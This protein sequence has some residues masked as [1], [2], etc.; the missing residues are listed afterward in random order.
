[1]DTGHRSASGGI[2]CC[3][4]G[5]CRIPDAAWHGTPGG[6]TNHDCRCS[7]CTG[8]WA[9]YQ[10]DNDWHSSYLRRLKAKGGNG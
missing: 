10:R 4:D 8:E 6:Y 2:V 9:K 7:D 1:V 5:E 3:I